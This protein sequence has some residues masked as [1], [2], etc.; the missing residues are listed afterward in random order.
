MA[1]VGELVQSTSGQWT[2][3]PP[4]RCPSGH[5]LRPGRMLVGSIASSCGRHLTW[6]CECGVVTYGLRWTASKVGD[7]EAG[8]PSLAVSAG[9]NVLTLHR[10]LGHAKASM[11]LDTYADLFDD[12]LVAVTATLHSRYSRQ[13]VVT[14]PRSRWP[15]NTK[16]G[17]ICGKRSTVEEVVEG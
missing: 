6:A 15:A 17:F 3:R 14:G 16:P 1:A 11:T 7:F 4:L 2:A 8:L 9:V 13:N 10:M 12:H 5:L